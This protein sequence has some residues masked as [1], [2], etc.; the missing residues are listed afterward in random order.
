MKIRRIL[1]KQLQ[2][3][4]HAIQ[5]LHLQ[6]DFNEKTENGSAPGPGGAE[7]VLLHSCLPDMRTAKIMPARRLLPSRRLG[8]RFRGAF[9]LVI[10]FSLPACS[11]EGNAR[12]MPESGTIVIG[13][14]LPACS[15]A[16]F[17]LSRLKASLSF[18]ITAAALQSPARYRQ[19]GA[20]V[21]LAGYR[22]R[23]LS[24]SAVLAKILFPA[25]GGRRTRS[26]FALPDRIAAY[27]QAPA[28]V[29]GFTI[30]RRTPATGRSAPSSCTVLKV[31]FAMPSHDS[32]GRL[33]SDFHFSFDFLIP[34]LAS[35]SCLAAEG[36]AL[37][38]IQ[39][40]AF[41]HAQAE[42]SSVR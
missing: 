7:S 16:F 41:A 14:S 23:P 22:N 11:Q 33:L 42:A 8:V 13:F 27:L 19:S 2:I 26:F 29:I 24:A 3:L 28:S 39:I 17:A 20:L 10:G 40:L 6:S 12:T 37:G 30:A 21:S 9:C 34:E 4:P 31:R 36:L 35:H 5:I 1:L 18:A 15:Q 32:C 25:P 38:G